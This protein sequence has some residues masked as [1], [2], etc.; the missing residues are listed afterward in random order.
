MKRDFTYIDDVVDAIIS[1]CEKPAIKS[2]NF[3][4]PNVSSS[5][6]HMIFNVGNSNPINLLDF[7]EIMEDKFKIKAVKQF[8]PI[9]P[10]DVKETYAEISNC[11]MDWLFS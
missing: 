3:Y 10:G 5:A 2:H 9:Q 1:C 6:P 8:M 4:N 7:I 11:K